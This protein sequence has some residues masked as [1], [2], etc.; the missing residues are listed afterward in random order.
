MTRFSKAAITAATAALALG[1]AGCEEMPIG[2]FDRAEISAAPAAAP[3]TFYF[4]PDSDLLAVGE[5]QRLTAYLKSI[6]PKP[7][8]DILLEVGNSG[9]AILDARRLQTLQRT[10][11]GQTRGARVRVF[12]PQEQPSPDKLSNAVKLT[13][14]RY[15]LIVVDCPPQELVGE[16][17]TPLPPLGCSNAINR[18]TMAA[19]KRDLIAPAGAL[20]GSEGNVSAAAVLRHRQGKV[21]TLPININGG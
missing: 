19:D 3:Y 10:F 13:L 17:T 15:D 20:K 11:G 5:A 12:V 8:Q 1:L 2:T 21:I 7:G 9:A 18:A 6:S 16:L 14:V 4:A